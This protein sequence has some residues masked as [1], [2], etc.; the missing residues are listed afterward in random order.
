MNS[1]NFSVS[2]NKTTLPTRAI[3]RMLTIKQTAQEFGLPE[4]F[5]RTLARSGKIVATRAGT[6]YL[7]NADKL[8]EF[9][10]TSRLGEEESPIV[11]NYR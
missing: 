9:L 3:P 4:H 7:I 5:V 10:N 8:V 2:C 11:A 1:P 6:K